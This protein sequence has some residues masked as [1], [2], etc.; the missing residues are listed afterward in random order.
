M[1]TTRLSTEKSQNLQVSLLLLSREWE[2]AYVPLPDGSFAMGHRGW[3]Q[4][5]HVEPET[6]QKNYLRKYGVKYRRPGQEW[7]VESAHLLERIPLIDPLAQGTSDGEEEG[8]EAQAGQ[9]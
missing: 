7:I 1:E 8:Q 9:R 6:F 5:F 4:L 2:T 3:G